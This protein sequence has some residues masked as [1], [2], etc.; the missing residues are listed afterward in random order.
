MGTCTLLQP[1]MTTFSLENFD[2]STRFSFPEKRFFSKSSNVPKTTFCANG[3]KDVANNIKAHVGTM[4]SAEQVI[5]TCLP[6]NWVQSCVLIKSRKSFSFKI[7][8]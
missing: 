1:L 2:Q 3:C 6:V 5:A 4:A 8:P 7:N